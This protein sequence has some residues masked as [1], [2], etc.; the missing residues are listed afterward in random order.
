MPTATLGAGGPVVSRIGLGLAALGR[1]AYITSGREQDLPDR[2]VAGLRTRTFSMLDAAYAAGV[3]YADA[4]R[5]YGRAEEFLAG[6]LAE[7]GHATWSSY[8]TFLE[9][10]RTGSL[11]AAAKRLGL[12]QPTAGR[13]IEALEKA[14]GLALF[15]R[16][17]RGLI[18]TAAAAGL[19]PH[20]KAMAAASAALLRT[21]SGEAQAES[22][23]VRLAASHVVGCEVLP[24]ILAA[25]R[26][27]HPAIV[28]ELALSDRN[29]DLLRREADIAVS[30]M[31]PMQQSLRAPHRHGRNRPFR[32]PP[33]RRALRPADYAGPTAA[34]LLDRLRPR[35]SFLPF[36][37][38]VG[39]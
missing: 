26:A 21:A 18:P 11:S 38:T 2:S 36:G 5:S 4:A 27:E 3:R 13:H 32:A 20:A 12:S 37:R 34:T 28:Q 33:L 1:P 15:S 9:A 22:G 31:R 29:E 23:T 16:T 35:R 8:R 19:V 25:F 6:W 10:A 24:P 17:P 39:G 7:R 14:L 30:M